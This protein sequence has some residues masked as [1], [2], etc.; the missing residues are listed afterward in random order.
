MG[1]GV[2]LYRSLR[3]YMGSC[4]SFQRLKN[5]IGIF[6]AYDGTYKTFTISLFSDT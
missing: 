2:I 4:D 5:Y 1:S 3:C 6:E